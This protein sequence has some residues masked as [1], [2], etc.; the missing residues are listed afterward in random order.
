MEGYGMLPGDVGQQSIL[1]A[2]MNKVTTLDLTNDWPMND[3]I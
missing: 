2:P 1:S 3:V